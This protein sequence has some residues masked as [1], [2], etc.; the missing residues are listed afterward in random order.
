MSNHQCALSYPKS[1]LKVLLLEKIAQDAVDMFKKEGFQVECRDKITEDELVE[2]IPS[3]HI[4]GVRSKTQV[5]RRVLEASRR[6][7]AVGCFCIGTDQTDLACAASNGKVVFNAPFSNTRSVAEMVMGNIIMLLRQICERSSECHVGKWN[8]VAS[9]CYEARGKV[10]GIIGYGHVGSQVSI[11]AEAFGMIV[12]YYDHVPKLALGNASSV[13]SLNEL[14]QISDIVTVHVPLTN[15]TENMISAKEFALMKRGSYFLNAARGTVIDVDALAAAVKSGHIAGCAVDVFPHE[16]A[17][18]AEELV[19]PLRGLPNTI[20]TPHI[21]GSTEEAQ[22]AIGKEVA[23]KLI[24]FVN[25]GSTLGAV[26]MPE[27]Q[28]PFPANAHRIL[29]FHKNVPGVLRDINNILSAYNVRGQMLMTQ[30]NEGYLIVDVETHVSDEVKEQI[31][32]LPASIKTRIL[33]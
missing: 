30:A 14:L 9:N 32:S 17:S 21:G 15:E 27:M 29:N 3:I 18:A 11:L 26:N 4:L 23:S 12:K 16:P 19:T 10:L 25:T 31:A 2:I 8:K 28:L 22:A 1:E 24:T 7:L 13:D 5:T 33:Y 20:L 6:L